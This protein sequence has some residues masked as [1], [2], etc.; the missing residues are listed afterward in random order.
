MLVVAAIVPYYAWDVIYHFVVHICFIAVV[1]VEMN[2][3]EKEFTIR[4]M[5]EFFPNSDPSIYEDEGWIRYVWRTKAS[6]YYFEL[7]KRTENR[8]HIQAGTK[9]VQTNGRDTT[10]ALV[11]N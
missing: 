5:R 11:T 4:F 6:R 2:N 9:E 1:V 8:E 7:D 10:K 3:N